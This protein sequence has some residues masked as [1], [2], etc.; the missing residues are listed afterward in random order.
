M[1]TRTDWELNLTMFTNV[2][3]HYGSLRKM[4]KSVINKTGNVQKRNIEARSY[5]HCCTGKAVLRIV[6][7]C[8]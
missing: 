4:T 7:V 3:I 2:F 5:N 6:S 8:L 1:I